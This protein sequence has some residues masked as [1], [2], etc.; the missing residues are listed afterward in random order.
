[1]NMMRISTRKG[2]TLIELLVVIAIIG[3]LSSVVLASL[4]SAREKSRD[5]RRMNDLR[6]I[7]RAMEFYYDDNGHYPRE[8]DG[9]NGIIGEGAGLDTMLAPYLSAIPRD[10]LG[11]GSGTYNY[12]YDGQQNCTNDGV[13]ER[14]AVIFARTMESVPTNRSD[15]CSGWGGEGGAGNANAWHIVVEPSDG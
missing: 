8:G 4:S 5:A 3:L 10:P 13:M 14:V 15:F 12:Y 11:P 6:Q 2:F 1:M 7:Q 9:A